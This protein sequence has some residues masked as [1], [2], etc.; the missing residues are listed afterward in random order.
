MR[1]ELEITTFTATVWEEAAAASGASQDAWLAVERPYGFRVAVID[2]STAPWDARGRA[3]VDAAAWAA[4]VVRC[5]LASDQEMVE[6]LERANAELHQPA[7]RSQAQSMATVLCVEPAG[8][9]LLLVRG[10]NC[11]AWISS[12]GRWQSLFGGQWPDD[13]VDAYKTTIAANA[14]ASAREI[15]ELE[16]RIFGTADAWV[17]APPGRFPQTKLEQASWAGEWD[18]LVLAT[19][20]ARL[21]HDRVAALDDWLGEIRAWERD[22]RKGY[23]AEKRHDDITVVRLRRR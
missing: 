5:A 13:V 11:E 20:G 7:L 12:G 23:A 21:D 6:A 9:G 17:S 19:D 18:E 14:D 2:G 8:D 22:A 10:G 4:G 15:S 1:F 3:G 16:E